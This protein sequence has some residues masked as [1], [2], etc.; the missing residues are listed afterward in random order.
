ME[1]E[2][3]P[4]LTVPVPTASVLLFVPG[5][6][7]VIAPEAVNIAPEFKDNIAFALP[8]ALDV[9]VTAPTVMVPPR[10]AVPPL[11]SKLNMPEFVNAPIF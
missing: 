1:K 4:A 7:I 3:L 10:L 11:L 6:G 9:K 5:R 2:I 8:P